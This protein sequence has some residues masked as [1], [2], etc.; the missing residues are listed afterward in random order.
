MGEDQLDDLELGG[1]I[2]LRILDRIAWDFA[3]AK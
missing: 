3:Q 1:T 2:A